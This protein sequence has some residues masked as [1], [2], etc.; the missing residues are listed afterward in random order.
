MKK[1]FRKKLEKEKAEKALAAAKKAEAIWN[2]RVLLFTEKS[3][4][5]VEHQAAVKIQERGFTVI[6]QTDNQTGQQ[7]NRCVDNR[8]TNRR[9]S[10]SVENCAMFSKK[11]I[12][13]PFG[14]RFGYPT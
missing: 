14:R 2:E 9:K 3:R 6:K 8:K 1:N 12:Q 7:L 11:A 10:A 13:V 5:R 4:R